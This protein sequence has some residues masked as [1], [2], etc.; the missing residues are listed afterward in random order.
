MNVE[1]KC[2]DEEHGCGLRSFFPPG[3][4]PKC[5]NSGVH[6]MH[7]DVRLTQTEEYNGPDSLWV[8]E[9]G[10]T[11]SRGHIHTPGAQHQPPPTFGSQSGLVNVDAPNEEHGL[12][13]DLYPHSLD[14]GTF[15]GSH[16]NDGL[17]LSG[18]TDEQI[19]LVNQRILELR[20]EQVKELTGEDDPNFKIGAEGAVVR[21]VGQPDT[22]PHTETPD[23]TEDEGD[24][25]V[26]L[27]GYSLTQDEVREV[28]ES[29]DEPQYED[30]P[31]TE[32][33]MEHLR[34][35]YRQV[36]GREADRRYGER[37]LYQELQKEKG[38]RGLLDLDASEV[39][40]LNPSGGPAPYPDENP[41]DAASMDEQPEFTEYV[42]ADN[43]Q[44]KESQVDGDGG[45]PGAQKADDTPDGQDNPDS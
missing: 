33:Q 20:W 6:S 40:G 17:D 13:P 45:N 36:T 27:G 41:N 23:A 5:P 1:Y 9:D 25:N 35:E 12:T 39:G 4:N 24:L 38:E 18:L 30:V 22:V 2:L 11:E 3:K 28:A 37:R 7:P 29:A 32:D 16:R 42:P 44:D 10:N 21:N 43:P 8:D 19:E 14:D 26:A 31:G 34:E 15:Q